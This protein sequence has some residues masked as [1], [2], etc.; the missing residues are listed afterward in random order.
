MYEEVGVAKV[1]ARGEKKKKKRATLDSL[2]CSS[3]LA[4]FDNADMSTR[5]APFA[6]IVVLWKVTFHLSGESV[7]RVFEIGDRV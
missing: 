6:C 3:W 2:W 1:A 7:S 4:A 5:L